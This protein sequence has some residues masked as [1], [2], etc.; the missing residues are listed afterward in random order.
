MTGRAG[1]RA[2]VALASLCLLASIAARTS[3]AP[4]ARAVA[5]DAV[6]PVCAAVPGVARCLALQLVPGATAP[7]GSGPRGYSPADLRAAYALSGTSG[8]G[9]TVAIVDAFDAPSAEA[10]LGVYRA[11]F[12]LPQCTSANGC[13]RKL[14][15]H[16]GTRYPRADTAWSRE[17][18][19]DLDMLSAACPDC[20][21]VLLEARSPAIPDLG[22]AENTAASLPGVVA[23]SNSY[24]IPENS[25]E[26]QWDAFYSHQGVAITAASGDGGYGTGYPAASP[27]VTAVGGTS[28]RRDASPRGWSETPWSGASSGCSQYEPKPSWQ[29]DPG[30]TQRS[31]ADVSAVADPATG[32]ALYDTYQAP[33]WIEAGGTSAA[34]AFIAGVYALAGNSTAVVAGSYPYGHT[35]ALNAVGGGYTPPAGLGT[36]AGTGAF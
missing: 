15:A 18:S 21:I 28:L 23:V 2:A 14:D 24:G 25:Q 4:S 3:P 33:G 32:V 9:R 20:H 22:V 11:T 35:G 29:H 26:T 12:G 19:L 8:Q 17:I 1:R 13:F 27:L 6:R 31:I 7:P 10:D 34:T 16:G 36:P 5:G 30:C